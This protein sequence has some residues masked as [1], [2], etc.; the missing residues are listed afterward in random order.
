MK[1]NNQELIGAVELS[2]LV[3]M[4][5]PPTQQ[6]SQI[7]EH[8]LA[9]LLVVAGAGAGK[10]ETMASRVVWLVANRLVDPEQV[11]GLTFTNKAARQLDQ[12]IRSRL[13]QLALSPDIAR[14]DPDHSLRDKIATT[15]P[16]VKTYDSYAGSLV[17]EY[18]L[19]LPVEPSSRL[20]TQTELFQIAY[21]VV[22]S[23]QG[24]LPTSNSVA[25]VTRRLL[26]LV[27]EMDNHMVDA[28]EIIEETKPVL[29]LVE[30][31]SEEAKRPPKYLADLAAVQKLRLAL[32]PLVEK[33]KATLAEK[34]L[35]TFGEQMSLAARLASQR[36]AVATSQRQR[37]KVI[38]LDEYQDTGHAQRILLK[39]LFAGQAVTA[40]GDPMQSIYG[41][42]GATAANLERFVVDFADGKTLADKKELTTSW[43]NP[44][45]VL[46]L[47]NSVS[48]SLL[49]RGN[50][51]RTVSPLSSR[52]G[53]PVGEV[54]LGF[55]DTRFTERAF[56]ADYL[57]KQYENRQQRFYDRGE[58]FTAAVLVRK[59]EHTALIAQE[60][61]DRGV[62]F[63]VVGLSGLLNIAEVADLI[64]LATILLRP[65]DN[66]AAMR[67]ISGPLVGLGIGDIEALAARARNLAAHAQVNTSSDYSEDPKEK[68]QQI[69]D[70]ISPTI[71]EAVVGLGDAIADLGEADRFSVEGYRRLTQ[72]SAHLR[73]LRNRS[74]RQSLPDLF[75]DIEKTFNIRTEV[76]V[77]QDPHADGA[78][79]TAHLDRFAQEVANFA[80]LPG[81]HLG[82]FLDYCA[83]AKDE[84][85]GLEPGEVH[86]SADR[87]QILTA[88]K[89]K[90][91]EWKIV[92]LLHTDTQTYKA[93]AET[94]LTKEQ[95]VPSTLR[96]D[97]AEQDNVT[98][99]PI[100]DL[101]DIEKP[102]DL[103]K[104]MDAH[105]AE[106]RQGQEEENARL[107]YVAM[108]RS[109][110]DLLITGALASGTGKASL[111]SPYPYFQQ[112]VDIRGDLVV[113]WCKQPEL[114][115]DTEFELPQPPAEYFPRHFE[116]LGQEAVY[117]ALDSLPELNTDGDLFE[118]WEQETTALIEEYKALAAPV[119][120]VTLTTELTATDIVAL[121]RDPE[122]F[123]RRLRRPIPFKPNSYAKRG[124]EFH[125]WLEDRFGRASLLDESELPGSGEEKVANVEAL[126]EAFLSSEWAHR[127]PMYVE[128][129]F[130]VSVGS[131]IIRGR[132]DAIFQQPDGSWFIVDWKTGHR[133]T[134]QELRSNR[135]Q[136]AV[137]RVAW[138]KLQGI[139]PDLVGAAFYYVGDKYLLAPQDLPD[140]KE[141]ARLVESASENVDS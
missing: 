79:G 129:P 80:K 93:K 72:L 66:T 83:L 108:T 13:H 55:F 11:L 105:K 82:A 111:D 9:P 33:L 75:A 121:S 106:F 4:K 112:L 70:E 113:Q 77:R 130:E 52:A 31:L 104:A 107:F 24:Q 14:I 132:M 56:V 99:A 127:T 94:W 89:A 45:I 65:Q 76:L 135:V 40:V 5:F 126:K 118:L 38:M 90:G 137:Y 61:A 32:L 91:L 139:D 12:R 2:Q 98:G 50:A 97:V 88:H 96:G 46:E 84:E 123:A 86:V 92:A 58:Q 119:V 19:L 68:L 114:T 6:Q 34:R 136:L 7:I 116:V 101:S 81:A 36:E 48:A 10:T 1:I 29:S 23:Y 20:I 140:E 25:T 64:A 134:A 62:P 51:P 22:E 3:G 17:S 43:R 115:G 53:A 49:E 59:N 47:A 100:L 95:H 57:Q 102:V 141:L 124:T 28:A 41:W 15:S 103:K 39:S 54:Q 16:T 131:H 87:V 44:D 69:I 109:E 125:Q 110:H 128:Q 26:H 85:S 63:E 18:G 8:G 120:E 138:A 74:L 42:R 37:F 67:I 35:I 71:P 117:Q 30:E 122:Q 60:L 78:A 21:H 133:P 27:S 73:M